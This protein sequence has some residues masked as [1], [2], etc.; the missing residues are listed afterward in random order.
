MTDL[1]AERFAALADTTDDRDWLDV[2]RRARRGRRLVLPAAALVTAAAAAAALAAGGWLFTAHSN[3]VTAT[4]TIAF[5]GSRYTL[6]V[7]TFSDGM[8]C[9]K[10]EGLRARKPISLCDVPV[11]LDSEARRR[12]TTWLPLD[13]LKI[14]VPGGQI[15]FGAARHDITKITVTNSAGRTFATTT[16]A[17]RPPA[18]SS[19][20]FWAIAAPGRIGSITAFNASGRV[21]KHVTPGD[22]PTPVHHP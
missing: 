7:D 1:L 20:R 3:G 2:R 16:V 19:I 8:L 6:T 18:R 10:L 22:V 9:L 4:R 5:H 13:T 14:G 12:F 17:T 21:V 11:P 15:A